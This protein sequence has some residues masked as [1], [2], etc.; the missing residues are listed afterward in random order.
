MPLW[1]VDKPPYTVE[2]SDAD[3]ESAPPGETLPR[4]HPKAKDGLLTRPAEGVD[5]LF[6]LVRRTADLYGPQGKGIATRRL[7][8]VHTET[9]KVKKVVD[10][11]QTE[12]DKE[13]QF[14]ELS[15]YTVTTYKEYETLILQV[16]A[17]LRK[18][19]LASPDRVHLFAS[20]R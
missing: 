4:R 17:G 18:I 14:F 6:D 7:L 2:V 11:Q 9:K 5:T 16:G 13:W 1:M 10:G 20:T 19:G 8:K 12:V 3:R 15:P